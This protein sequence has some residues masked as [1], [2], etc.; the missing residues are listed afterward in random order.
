[1]FLA[2]KMEEYSAEIVVVIV[3][4]TAAVPGILAWAS[5][6]RMGR[7]NAA[8]SITTSAID[9]VKQHEG[10][11]TKLQ[12][13]IDRLRAELKSQKRMVANLTREVGVLREENASLRSE[14]NRL[15][16]ELED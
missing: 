13:Q 8:S 9:L 5:Q 4:L 6:R 15:L 2:R 14:N 7:V 1:M 12:S 3:A 11:I 10:L 16:L